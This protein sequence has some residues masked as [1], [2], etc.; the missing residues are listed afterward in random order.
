MEFT[1]F[2]E[3]GRTRVLFLLGWGNRPDHGNVRWL[4]DQLAAA[5]YV[6]D[7]PSVYLSP[8]WGLA[9]E[10]TRLERFLVALP[11]TRPLLPVSTNRTAIGDL[12][13][14]RQLDDI[15]DRASPAFLRMVVDAQERLPPFRSD[16]V[17]FCTL[18]DRIVGVDAI[19]DRAPADRT[20]LYDGG[21]ELFSSPSRDRAVEWV[22]AALADGPDA[23]PVQGT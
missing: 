12:A 20:V 9:D 8:W 23:L 4:V 13:T 10:G 5:G 21:H 14:D 19:G 15:P 1:E 6:V 11:T 2:G 17:V 18:S 22:L 7:V 3:G 16:S